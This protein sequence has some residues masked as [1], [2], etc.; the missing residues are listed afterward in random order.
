MEMPNV[1]FVSQRPV[2]IQL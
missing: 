1:T 2:K